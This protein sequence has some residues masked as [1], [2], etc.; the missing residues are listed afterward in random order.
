MLLTLKDGVPI[1]GDLVKQIIIRN[2]L[3]AVPMTLEV[4]FVAG[5]RE[6]AELLKEGE[7]L[8]DGLGN[9]FYILKTERTL[10]VGTRSADSAEIIG[11]MFVTAILNDC[12]EV[13]FVSEKGIIKE[14][15]TLSQV[16]KAAGCKIGFVRNDLTV[17]R[18]YCYAGNTPTFQIMQTLQEEGAVVRWKEKRLQFLRIPDL[19]KQKP[20][21]EVPANG[22][23]KDDA[24]FLERHDIP[25]FYSVN[26]Q[27]SVIWGNRSKARSARFVPF[28]S[29][30]A[31]RNMSRCLVRSRIIEI[32]LDERICAG[33][34][35]RI[36]GDR[37]YVVITAAHVWNSGVDSESTPRALTKLWLG[38]MK[39]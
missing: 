19:F 10:K 4:E 5:T 37:D 33:D 16:Y 34:L 35:I 31:L 6:F 38:V 25:S 30:Q 29:Q 8:T 14:K 21:L 28:K 11:G 15:C 13:A 20:I 39:E 24:G 12:K 22:A 36:I 3:T 17:S 9:V 23:K 2:D 1:R 26:D 32:D 7:T 18:F 27:G